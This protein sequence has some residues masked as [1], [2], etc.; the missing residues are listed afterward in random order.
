MNT[1]IVLNGQPTSLDVV[2]RV[3]QDSDVILC[4]DGGLATLARAGIRPHMLLGDM[5][6]AQVELLESWE[7]QG[8]AIERHNPHKDETDGQLAV[9]WAIDQG[10]SRVTLL[11]ALGGRPDHALGNFMLLRRLVDA[12]V[13]AYLED[14]G[15]QV[16][17]VRDGCVLLGQPGQTFSVLPLG[18]GLVVERLTGAEYPLLSP[19]PMP[20]N[21]PL[22]ISNVFAER[23]VEL[24]LCSGIALVFHFFS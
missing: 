11:C 21:L 5:D 17:A 16:Q 12:G 14:D 20:M 7:C 3:C 4:A 6:S 24:Q 19:T 23:Q 9:D 10:A 15:L 22:G 2:R 18:E 1:V 13:E 8:G